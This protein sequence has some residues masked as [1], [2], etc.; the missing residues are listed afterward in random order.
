M[1]VSTRLYTYFIL[2]IQLFEA[3]IYKPKS[4]S[5]HM[6][7]YTHIFACKDSYKFRFR[8]LRKKEPPRDIRTPRRYPLTPGSKVEARVM[9]ARAVTWVVFFSHA[10]GTADSAG[11]HWTEGGR[12]KPKWEQMT[13]RW[14]FFSHSPDPQNNAT[15]G[16]QG[17]M[18]R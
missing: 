4:I 14:Y 13:C 2:R 12:G 15:S 18:P 5:M 1:Y 17:R 11:Q 6:R 3:Y 8:C 9:A 7:T 10:L 16:S